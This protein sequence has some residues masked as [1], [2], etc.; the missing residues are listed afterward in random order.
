MS[1]SNIPAVSIDVPQFG[2][3]RSV[4]E[5]TR[6]RKDFERIGLYYIR[7]E[8][9]TIFI[10]N[11]NMPNKVKEKMKEPKPP[12]QVKKWMANYLST[13]ERNRLTNCFD[14]YQP[15][16]Q[17]KVTESEQFE[18]MIDLLVEELQQV[19]MNWSHYREDWDYYADTTKW[20]NFL[21]ILKKRQAEWLKEQKLKMA[22]NQRSS[23][24]R[25]KYAQKRE[26]LAE[27]IQTARTTAETQKMKTPTAR[28]K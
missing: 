10:E 11:F 3:W 28:S 18:F 21:E 23:R 15:R 1:H 26:D 6:N 24:A 12:H 2:N 16:V 7:S 25:R 9:N 22:D 20:L 5:S 4:D 27:R 8:F 17:A 13:S 14:K 19:N